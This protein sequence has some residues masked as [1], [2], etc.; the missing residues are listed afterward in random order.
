MTYDL[1]LYRFY[2]GQPVSVHDTWLDRWREA[3]VVKMT[4]GYVTADTPS[5]RYHLLPASP[6]YV[7]PV[8]L[9]PERTRDERRAA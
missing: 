3:T 2:V 6:D 9:V 7:R 8:Y 4:L 5:Y 1:R